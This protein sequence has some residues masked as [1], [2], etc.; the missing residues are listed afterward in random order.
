MWP[1]VF[2]P[3][4]PKSRASGSSPTPSESH[5]MTIARLVIQ[6]FFLRRS[7]S[8]GDGGGGHAVFDRDLRADFQ[9]AGDLRVCVTSD[10]PLL[11][12]F[13]DGDRRGGHFEDRAGDLIRLRRTERNSRDQDQGN[14]EYRNFLRH[15]DSPYEATSI[16]AAVIASARG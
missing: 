1:R 7:F 16:A 5:T 4:S 8:D 13:L 3:S 10:F 12:A 11:A 2:E 6:L 14:D 9:L 15:F